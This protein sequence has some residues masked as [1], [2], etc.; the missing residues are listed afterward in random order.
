MSASS[1]VMWI[2]NVCEMSLGHIDKQNVNSKLLSNSR[3]I[4]DMTHD[5]GCQT[6]EN[7][8]TSYYTNVSDPSRLLLNDRPIDKQNHSFS[9]DQRLKN[10]KCESNCYWTHKYK[11]H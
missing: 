3:P 8:E 1:A 6:N 10:Q 7:S 4:G 9:F 5:C 11:F 2:V